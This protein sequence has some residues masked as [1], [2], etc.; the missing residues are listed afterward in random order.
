MPTSDIL[1]C[2]LDD[3]SVLRLTLNYPRRRN[4]LSEAMLRQ[5]GAVFTE[6]S[7]N[8]SARV[9]VLAADG[10]PSAPGMILRK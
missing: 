4:A 2:G 10:R 7:D 8:P 5:L 1:L 6:A 9:I 3:D